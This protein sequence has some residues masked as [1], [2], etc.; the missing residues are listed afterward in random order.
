MVFPD[1]TLQAIAL[2][3]PATLDALRGISG[4]G[5]KKRDTFG[6]ALLDLMRSGDVR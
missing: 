1:A 5:D 2:A 6:P 3:R 4:V